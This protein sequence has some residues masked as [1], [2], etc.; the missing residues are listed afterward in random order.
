MS[1]VV[2][3]YQRT[4]KLPDLAWNRFVC[5]PLGAVVVKLCEATP[6]TPNQIT[7]AAFGVACVAAALLVAWPGYLGLV[8]AI[9]VYEF[10]YVLDCA[11]GMLARLRGIASK[12]GHLLDFLMDEIKAFLILAAVSVRLFQETQAPWMLLLGVGGLV[13]LATGIAVT[14]FQRRPEIAGDAPEVA[15]PVAAP[16]LARRLLG[17]PMGVAKLL[18]HYPSYIWLAAALGHIEYYFYPHLAVISLYAVKSVVWLGLR[19]GRFA[20]GN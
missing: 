12:Q 17:V 19:Y 4:K 18:V 8:V 2:E 15:A 7:L 1:G 6:I 3:I 9:V 10:S 11:D 20:R 5:R 13:M 16:S 14:T